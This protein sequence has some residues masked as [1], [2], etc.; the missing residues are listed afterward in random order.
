SSCLHLSSRGM[1]L[2]LSLLLLLLP[3]SSSNRFISGRWINEG[4]PTRVEGEANADTLRFVQVLWRHGDRTPAILIPTDKE[5]GEETWPEGLG[6][7]TTVGMAQQYRLGKWL[8]ERYGKYLG[9][10][11]DRAAV[12][13]RSSDYNRTLMSAQANLA[14]LFPPSDGEKFDKN[15]GW[16][17]IPVHTVPR[18]IDVQL[19]EEIHCPTAEADKDAIFDESPRAIQVEKENAKLLKFLKEKTGIADLRLK[20]VWT[21]F[22]S[23]NAELCHNGTHKWPEWMNDSLWEKIVKVYDDSSRLAFHTNTLRRLRGGPLVHEVLDR[24][25]AKIEGKLEKTKMYAYSAHDTTLAA[26][27]ATFGIFPVRFP[28]YATAIVIEMH[29]R[30]K[31]YYIEMYHKNETDG[32]DTFKHEMEGCHTP[33]KL[34]TLKKAMAPYEPAD[35][36]EECGLSKDNTLRYIVA[37]TVLSLTTLL[38]GSIIAVDVFLKYRNRHPTS[39]S[40]ERLLDEDETNEA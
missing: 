8:R 5:N 20:T 33:C 26:I 21:V 4:N 30:G 24:F 3:L 25:T 22:D 29:Q 16:Q 17:P 31:E 39:D 6:E 15:I 13:V 9:E 23:L 10:K 2:S 7:L 35:W 34:E 38:F 19:Y 14:G 32:K 40:S 12:H 37:I 28:L 27:L 18:E 11:W 36:H 1:P